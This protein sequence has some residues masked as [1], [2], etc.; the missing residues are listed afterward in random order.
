[1]EHFYGLSSTKEKQIE[2]GKNSICI[3]LFHLKLALCLFQLLII[4]MPSRLS[5]FIFL[6]VSD[7]EIYCLT[8]VSEHEKIIYCYCDIF[9]QFHC[10]F[11]NLFVSILFAQVSFSMKIFLLITL[12]EDTDG[13][14]T[15]CHIILLYFLFSTSINLSYI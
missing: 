8:Y 4:F 1:M 2:R 5:K 12:F 6:K 3:M 10:T 15:S 7:N 9:S 11:Y 13:K 14:Q